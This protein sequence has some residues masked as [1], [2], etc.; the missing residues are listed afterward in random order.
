MASE[1][2]QA[3]LVFDSQLAAGPVDGFGS[4]FGNDSEEFRM[5]E[6]QPGL[7]QVSVE[8]LRGILDSVFFLQVVFRRRQTAVTDAGVAAGDLHLFQDDDRR[9]AFAGLQ[10]SGQPRQPTADHHNVGFFIPAR[11]PQSP[12]IEERFDILIRKTGTINPSPERR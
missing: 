6:S 11:H 4:L 5:V 7:Q 12:A 8:P 9:P 10:G 3:V 1:A 2:I